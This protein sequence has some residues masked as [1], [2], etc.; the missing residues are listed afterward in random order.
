M[1]GQQPCPLPTKHNNF[2][3]EME[4]RERTD[5]PVPYEAVTFMYSMSAVEMPSSDLK[6]AILACWLYK[7]WS[8]SS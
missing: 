3:K 2:K 4:R 6:L 5:R 8:L 7:S 1:V